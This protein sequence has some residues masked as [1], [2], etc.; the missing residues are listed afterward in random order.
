MKDMHPMTLVERV[1]RMRDIAKVLAVRL[2]KESHSGAHE[3]GNLH[4]MLACLH[5]ELKE[6]TC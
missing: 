5:W 1:E 2:A 3:S 6:K 4:D